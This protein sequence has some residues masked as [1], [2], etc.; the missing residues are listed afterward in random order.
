MTTSLNIRAFRASLFG[1]L[2][3]ATLVFLPAGTLNYWQAWVFLSVFAGASAAITVHLAITDP[4]LLERRMKVGPTAETEPTQKLA[5][6]LAIAGFAALLAVPAFDH[7]F[8]WSR[9]PPS[10]ALV[11]DALVGLCFVFMFLVLKE[12]PFSASTV[13][14]VKDQTVISTGPYAVVRHPMYA[15]ALLL[16]VG[17]PL[18]LG[19]WWGLLAALLLV[20]A[21]IWRLVDE[22]AFLKRNLPGY[23]EYARRVR[24]RL[25]PLVW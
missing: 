5:V 22:E 3:M 23:A 13:Q 24:H 21:L 9:V 8:G 1:A 20:P 6:S 7:R 25:V 15:A 12:N 17:T 11:G 4:A 18:A 16:V 10:G 19:S 14:V 2:L